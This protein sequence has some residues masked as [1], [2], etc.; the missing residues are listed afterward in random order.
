MDFSYNGGGNP[1]K[2]L[3]LIC[4]IIYL[5]D[6]NTVEVRVFLRGDKTPSYSLS[7]QYTIGEAILGATNTCNKHLQ[8]KSHL[9]ISYYIY[10]KD[11]VTVKVR[12]FPRLPKKPDN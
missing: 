8:Q 5:K 1:L 9:D 11:N 12:V 3:T 7:N 2:T 4:Y 10:L 6:N